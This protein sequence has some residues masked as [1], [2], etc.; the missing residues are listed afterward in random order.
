MTYGF[1]LSA[2]RK[3]N[4]TIIFIS[5]AD[6]LSCVNF[7]LSGVFQFAR[8]VP[9]IPP[10]HLCGFALWGLFSRR[11]PLCHDYNKTNS[12]FD[13]CVCT[14]T[15]MWERTQQR[16]YRM[17]PLSLSLSLLSE[18]CKWPGGEI[19]RQNGC[20]R[21]TFYRRLLWEEPRLLRVF[22]APRMS[23]PTPLSFLRQF[24]HRDIARRWEVSRFPQRV[25]ATLFRPEVTLEFQ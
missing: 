16:L 5:R 4:I 13:M 18:E 15:K 19:S 22:K 1:G 23:S 3:C 21:V 24:S 6:Y 20:L 14:R 17:V 25:S 12:V 11:H 2:A 10:D 8:R 9:S 7:R